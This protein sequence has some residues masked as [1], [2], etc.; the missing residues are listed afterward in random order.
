[1][2]NLDIVLSLLSYEGAAT[3]DPANGIKIKNKIQETEITD[4]SLQQI[5]VADSTT[6]QAIT[7]PAANSD[8][9]I[10]LADRD[11]SIKL[12]GSADPVALKARAN[13]TK[14]LMFYTRGLI[15]SLSLSNSSGALVNV[16]ILIANK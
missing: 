14:T 13:G 5:K 4:I 3:N 2:K 11:I 8:Y 7:L 12:N 6:D 10:I 1:M 15:T 16:D 9:L